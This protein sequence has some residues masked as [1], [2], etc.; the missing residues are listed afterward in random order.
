MY[1]RTTEMIARTA[2]KIAEW[3]KCAYGMTAVRIRKR[4]MYVP[5]DANACRMNK[6]IVRMNETIGRMNGT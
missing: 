2:E 4:E 6:M 3:T 5:A 1:S